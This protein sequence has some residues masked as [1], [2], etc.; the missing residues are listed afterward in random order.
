MAGPGRESIR[1][2]RCRSCPQLSPVQSPD[3]NPS[4]PYLWITGSSAPGVDDSCQDATTSDDPESA[5]AVL[6]TLAESS[7]VTSADDSPG[8]VG[9]HPNMQQQNSSACA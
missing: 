9:Q 8:A 2:R 7:D 6:R 3:R 1:C 4:S 5:P